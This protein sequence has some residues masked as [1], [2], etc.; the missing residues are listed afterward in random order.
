MVPH[1][2]NQKPTVI[3]NPVSGRGKTFRNW[4]KMKAFLLRRFREIRERFTEAPRHAMEIARE[5]IKRGVEHIIT[6]GGDGTLNEVINGFFENFKPINPEAKV[7]LLPSGRGNDFAKSLRVH[8]KRLTFSKSIEVDL[9]KMR[10]RLFINVLD[11]GLGGEI[12]SKLESKNN[13]GIVYTFCLFREFFRYRPKEYVIYVDGEKI[14]GKF[15]TVIVANGTTFGGGMK[16][17]PE[18]SPSDGI[19]DVVAIGE[20]SPVEFMLNIWRLY[21]GRLLSHPKVVFRKGRKIKIE[22]HEHYGEFDG[23]LFKASNLE[24]EVIKGGVEFLL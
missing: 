24:L 7:S 18:A 15:L 5:E 21:T 16:V 2:L 19:L 11:M 22:T 10:D 14:E 3:V 4:G 13:S 1:Y 9:V 8:P 23:E 12:V 20:F 17:A 6:V